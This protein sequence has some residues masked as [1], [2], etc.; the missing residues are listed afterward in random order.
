MKKAKDGSCKANPKSKALKVSHPNIA[1]YERVRRE[2]QKRGRCA[3]GFR[4]KGNM[5]MKK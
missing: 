5:C 2:G 1:G 3:G 4:K